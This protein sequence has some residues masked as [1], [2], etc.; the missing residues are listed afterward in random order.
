[1]SHICFV[2]ALAFLMSVFDPLE[3][4][5]DEEIKPRRA[6][7]SLSPLSHANLFYKLCNPLVYSHLIKH[8]KSLLQAY[9]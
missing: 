7:G 1:M 8:R 9:A 4:P 5:L 3:K 2:L 6:G